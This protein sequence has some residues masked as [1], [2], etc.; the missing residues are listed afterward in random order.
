MSIDLMMIHES[1]EFRV[2]PIEGE[3]WLWMWYR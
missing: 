2:I 1:L 3:D